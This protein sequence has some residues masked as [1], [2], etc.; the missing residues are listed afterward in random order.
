MLSRHQLA[1]FSRMEQ[2]GADLQRRF[3]ALTSAHQYFA[4]PGGLK[5]LSVSDAQDDGGIEAVFLGVRIR[6]Q[7]VLIFNDAFEPRGRVICTQCQGTFDHTGCKNLGGFIFDRDGMTDLED[8]SD[9]P[10]ISLENNAEQIVLVFLEKAFAANR[11][12]L[13]QVHPA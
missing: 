2:E 1:R 3:R 12:G 9:G 4:G 13:H 10:G 8:C 11:N 5:F 7:M 6:F